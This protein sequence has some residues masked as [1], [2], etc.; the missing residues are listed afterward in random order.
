M[1]DGE[2]SSIKEIFGCAARKPV[3]SKDCGGACERKSN[4]GAWSDFVSRYFY[5][6]GKFYVSGALQKMATV[7]L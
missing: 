5:I 6:G 3:P 2:P 1:S 7:N 4:C